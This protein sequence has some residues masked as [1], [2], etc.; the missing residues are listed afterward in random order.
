MPKDVREK[1]ASDVKQVLGE[2][3]IL[4]RLI[5]TG[6]NV[7]PG[8]PDEFEKAMKAQIAE[9]AKVGK[10]LNLKPGQQ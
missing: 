7:S 3:Q 1:I 5:A 6:Q 9:V 10:E 2:P 4:S 8:T